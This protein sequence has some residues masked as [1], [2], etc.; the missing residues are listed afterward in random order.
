MRESL[1]QRGLRWRQHDQPRLRPFRCSLGR[2]RPRGVANLVAASG[3]SRHLHRDGTDRR[4]RA[5]ARGRVKAG[6][7]RVRAALAAAR[8]RID[9]ERLLRARDRAVHDTRRHRGLEG[10]RP[11]ARYDH[12]EARAAEARVP[13]RRRG[14]RRQQLSAQRRRRCGRGHERHTRASWASSRSRA[15]SPARSRGSTPR[16]WA[17][18]PWRRAERRCH[19]RA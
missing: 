17:S 16:S 1:R 14:H 6:D 19:A 18:A 13:S 2:A 4:E 9:G 8:R 12:R 3:P 10:R 7:G 15:S 5:R 11:A